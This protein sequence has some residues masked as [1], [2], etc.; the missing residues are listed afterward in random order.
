MVAGKGAEEGARDAAE[1]VERWVVGVDPD[2][3][4]R[5]LGDRRHPP[6]EMGVVLPEF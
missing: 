4:P 1:R 5:G 2:E 3:D 6:D